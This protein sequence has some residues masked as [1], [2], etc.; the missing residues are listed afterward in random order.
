MPC[1]PHGGNP[2]SSVDPKDWGTF[3]QAMWHCHSYP[4]LYAGLG[5]V[6]VEGIVGI[7]LDKCRNKE[8][9]EIDSWAMEIISRI[10]SYTELSPSG[11]GVHIIAYGKV[12]GPRCKKGNYEIYDS[13]RFFTVTGEVLDPIVPQINEHCQADLDWFYDKVFGVEPQVLPAAIPSSQ[14]TIAYEQLVRLSVKMFESKGGDQAMALWSGRYDTEKYPSGSEADLALM[15]KLAFWCD[16]NIEAMREM[17]GM[18]E[19][20]K[21][22]KWT[23]RKDYQDRTINKA[24]EGASEGYQGAK[25]MSQSTQETWDQITGSPIMSLAD[26][27]MIDWIDK[28]VEYHIRPLCPKGSL[29]MLQGPAKGGKSTFMLFASLCA[30][31]GEWRGGGIFDVEAPKNVLF[32][33]Y[34]DSNLLFMQNISADLA[35]LGMD[36]RSPPENFSHTYYPILQMEEDKFRD[37]FIAEINARKIDILVLDTF[38]HVH[39]AEDENSASDMKPVMGNL[40][41]IAAATGASVVFIHHISKGASDK[42]TTEKSRG[43]SKIANDADVVIDWNHRP[44]GCNTTQVDV[45]SKL[46]GN[47]DFQ[48]EYREERNHEGDLMLVNWS[49]PDQTPQTDNSSPALVMEAIKIEF[50]K[51][52]A[53]VPFKDIYERVDLAKQTIRRHIYELEKQGLVRVDRLTTSGR[54]Q[55]V[56]PIA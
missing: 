22:D 49:F 4:T 28:K 50:E 48:V 51:T 36:R 5:F 41:R 45:K 12:K 33:E 31:L 46:A 42:P 30:T 23:E 35:G 39:Q 29:I 15:G 47:F 11:T 26:P 2:A 38:S 27:R 32:V 1:S 13:K 34:E 7:D 54:P 9:G 14:S 52:R 19:L 53:S 44:K 21:R 40:K 20:G 43:S 25:A 6:F 24:L 3:E 16:R 18:S 37:L 55:E 17:F 8:T 10:D 56:R